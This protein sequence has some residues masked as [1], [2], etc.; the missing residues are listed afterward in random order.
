MAS[1]QRSPRRDS[2]FK[3][4][5]R[6]KSVPEEVVGHRTKG[7]LAEYRVKWQGLSAAHNTWEN[8]T[9][10]KA[11]GGADLIREYYL[12]GDGSVRK[13][14]IDLD[15]KLRKMR[16]K[17]RLAFKHQGAVYYRLCFEDDSLADVPSHKVRELHQRQLVE[18]LEG[19]IHHKTEDT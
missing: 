10:L 17:I 8:E 13:R 11:A 19:L 16:F 2:S 12:R 5:K 4:S 1:T 15:S 6:E 7:D 18:F 9:D 3:E 14:T